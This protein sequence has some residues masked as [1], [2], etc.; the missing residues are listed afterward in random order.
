MSFFSAKCP[1]HLFVAGV[2]A[3]S[4][5]FALTKYFEKKPALQRHGVA[6]RYSNAIVHGNTIYISGQVGE[7]T[8]IK[9]Q[10]LSALEAVDDALCT[11]GSDKS[12]I[13]EVTVWLADINAD[14]AAMNEVYDQWIIAGSPP[15]RACVQ[16]QLYSP[17]CKVE[18]RVIA[19]L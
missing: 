4:T 15:C 17:S 13:M 18:I 14:Y 16:A 1:F 12:K 3:T 2:L 9:E 7:G 10:T 5:I 11:A 19:S 8:T 6:G